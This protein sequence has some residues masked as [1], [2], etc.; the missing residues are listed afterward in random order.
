[1][2]KLFDQPGA[3]QKLPKLYIIYIIF[4]QG[5]TDI[6]R[7]LNPTK[8]DYMHF[9]HAHQS[10]ARIDHLLVTNALI[11]SVNKAQITD[12]VWSDHSMISITVNNRAPQFKL[13]YWRLKGM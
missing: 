4:Q 10:Y 12:M 2:H 11:P 13:P 5:L 7:E 6:W 3:V 8:K 9:S 1:M